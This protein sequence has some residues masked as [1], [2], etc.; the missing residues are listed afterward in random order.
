M[1]LI[2]VILSVAILTGCSNTTQLRSI[3]ERHNILDERISNKDITIGNIIFR[4]IPI[5]T[6]TMG[7]PLSE[8]ARADWEAQ[9]KVT[10]SR[11]FWMGK[12][13]VTQSQWQSI[14]G[15][16]PSQYSGANNPVENV[17]WD[18]CQEFIKKLNAKFKAT[19]PLG[20]VFDLPTAAQWEY[21]CRAGTTTTFH[22]G[23]S[24]NTSQANFDKKLWKTTP[25]GSYRSNA[26][27]LY[28]MHGNVEEWC[29]D[30][31]SK[32]FLSR[33]PGGV[34]DPESTE[35]DTT[36]A[37]RWGLKVRRGGSWYSS[38]GG[39]RSASHYAWFQDS[40]ISHGTMGLR[41]VLRSQRMN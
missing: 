34:I 29:R 11:G 13:E 4:R 38:A 21:A 18:D 26:F 32:D 28:D 24:L 17:S 6:F 33:Y 14:M 22:F 16:N 9:H 2:F 41:L 12:Y 15:S 27:G 35:N 5:G 36:I 25:V 20:Y 30:F 8:K 23:N 31:H 10:L 39:C 1:K 19:L 37:T 3:Q 40:G 7:S